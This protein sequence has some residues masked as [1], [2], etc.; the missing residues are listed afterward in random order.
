MDSSGPFLMLPSGGNP[1]EKRG[2]VSYHWDL[3]YRGRNSYVIF[4]AT[5]AGEGCFEWAGK[6]HPVP[7]GHAFI[8]VVPEDSRYSFPAGARAAWEFA[9]INFHGR[10]GVEFW[11]WLREAHGPVV[12][13]PEASPAMALLLGLLRESRGNRAV[14]EFQLSAEAYRFAMALAG[15]LQAA[16]SGGRSPV[17]DMIHL[18]QRQP[19][20]PLAVK[21]LA[22]RAGMSREHFTRVFAR[23]TGLSPAAYRRGHQLQLAAD[24]LLRSELSVQDIAARCG[25]A[26]GRQLTKMFGRA[27]G[28]P[29]LAY[30]ARARRAVL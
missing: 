25:F 26:N 1:R 3:R 12:P 22:A 21:E 11:S 28:I 19:S 20:R 23:E 27:R 10:Q 15:Q 14:D 4:Q 13:L 5:R 9:W 18:M 8:A 29:P 24:W 6:R 2:D 16:R 7:A 17:R 30:R